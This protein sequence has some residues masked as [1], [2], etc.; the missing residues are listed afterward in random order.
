[1]SWRRP[2]SRCTSAAA[3][4]SGRSVC[5]TG[6]ASP[7]ASS[8]RRSCCELRPRRRGG[9]AGR[10]AR[11]RRAGPRRSAP[12]AHDRR[13]RRPLG[14]TCGDAPEARRRSRRRGDDADRQPARVGRGH[15]RLFPDRRRGA[16]VHRAAARQGPCVAHRGRPAQG[17]PGRRAQPR[18]ARGGAAGRRGP[19]RARRAPL[20]RRPARDRRPRARRS[21]P[22]HVHVGDERRAQGRPARS[23]LPARPAPAGGVLARC[24]AGRPGVVHGGQR[25]EQ[26]GAQRLHRALDPGRGRAAARR[27]LRPARAPGTACPRARRASCAWPRPSTA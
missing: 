10:Q 26:I 2:A 13:G 9:R 16:A 12:R 1:M 6:S 18:R 4:R 24:A 11:A 19:A 7:R 25:V 5:A 15:G 17:H 22:D 27:A 8:A 21:V 14:A 20:R 23:A 3:P